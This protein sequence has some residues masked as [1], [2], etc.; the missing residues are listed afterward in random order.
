MNYSKNH[1]EVGDLWKIRDQSSFIRHVLILEVDEKFGVLV[2]ELESDRRYTIFNG[3]R[4]DLT[5]EKVS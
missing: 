1:Y 3:S 5:A 2:M 4:Y